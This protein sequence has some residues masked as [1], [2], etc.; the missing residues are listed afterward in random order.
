MPLRTQK[1]QYLCDSRAIK[2]TSYLPRFQ[3]EGDQGWWL[4]LESSALLRDEPE[5]NQ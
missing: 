3:T 1:G 4:H 5:N 2:G